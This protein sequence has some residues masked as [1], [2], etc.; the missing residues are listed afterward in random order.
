MFENLFIEG[1]SRVLSA[2]SVKDLPSEAS[3][4][5]FKHFMF[6]YCTLIINYEW[7]PWMICR[8]Y[9]SLIITKSNPFFFSFLFFH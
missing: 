6:Y 9:E 7:R 2:I 4:L 5:T 3:L 8:S 1:E